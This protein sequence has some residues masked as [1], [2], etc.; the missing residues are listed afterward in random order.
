MKKTS[1]IL[2]LACILHQILPGNAQEYEEGCVIAGKHPNPNYNQQAGIHMLKPRE[3]G[4]SF[5]ARIKTFTIHQGRS[6]HQEVSSNPMTKVKNLIVI[7]G[8]FLVHQ[9]GKS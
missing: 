2:I 7:F 4:I 3:R 1:M 9:N 5:E 6:K 8:T